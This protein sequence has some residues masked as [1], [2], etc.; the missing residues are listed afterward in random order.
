LA[1]YL[2]VDQ[3]ADECADEKRNRERNQHWMNGMTG[4]DR[5]AAGIGHGSLKKIAGI[6]N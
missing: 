1:A 2:P 4:Y 6:F 3:I 5:R